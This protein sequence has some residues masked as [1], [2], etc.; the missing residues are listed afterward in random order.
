MKLRFLGVVVGVIALVLVA[1]D[2]PLASYISRTERDRL[3][4]TLERDAYVL[5]GKV[6]SFIAKND[7]LARAEASTVLDEF[8]TT[9]D[10][11]AVITNRN[12]YLLASTSPT[13][14]AG[15]DYATR[16]EVATAL[17]GSFASGVRASNT[18][19]ES[20]IYVAVPI[21]SGEQVLGVVR[22]TYPK[23]TIDARVAERVRSLALAAAV[24]LAIAVFAAFMLA[25]LIS[26]PITVLRKATDKIAA[27]DLSTEVSE[28]GPIE[29]KQLARSFNSMATRVRNMLERQRSFSGDAAHQMRTPLTALRLR[30]EQANNTIV[31]SPDLARDHIDAALNE[32][33]RL[34]NLTEQLL[35][36]ARTEG[37]VLKIED[38]DLRKVCQEICDEWSFLAEENAI[39]LSNCVREQISCRTSPLALREI[40]GNYIDN[41]IEHSPRDTKIEI[42]AA[43]DAEFLTITVRDQG[44]GLSAEQRAHAFDR[45]WRG[46][47]S[48]DSNGSREN[49]G[50]GMGLAV[51]AQLATASNMTLELDT[52]PFAPGLDAKVKIRLS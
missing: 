27:G 23:S 41:A 36:L 39:E 8:A 33:D 40:L 4:T 3:I 17:L 1:H 34:S 14:I 19:G 12:G 25:S 29:T 49:Q 15:E 47:P 42:H 22:L 9:N 52:S 11:T 37:A 5:S 45:F 6:N 46:S 7:V 28:Q 2:V 31:D 24:S 51:A 43:Q 13:D 20:L 38:V 50:S 48:V 35:R 16:P 32:T 44:P 30:L 26:R 10:A 21:F 18:I